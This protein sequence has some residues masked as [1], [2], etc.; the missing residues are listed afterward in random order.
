MKISRGL[1]SVVLLLS[2]TA[3]SGGSPPDSTPVQPAAV[4]GTVHSIT[5]PELTPVMP[6]AGDRKL[7]LN[8]CTSCH[9]ARY[10]L[11]QF[12]LSRE[13]W[14]AEVHKMHKAFGCPV[15]DAQVAPIVDYLMGVRQ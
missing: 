14:T 10:V 5:L 3:V 6:E 12:E 1:L 15:G 13:V 2:L 9:S 8:T 7:F 11:M 4:N